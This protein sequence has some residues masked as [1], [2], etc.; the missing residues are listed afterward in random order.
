MYRE[1]RLK[2][3]MRDGHKALGCWTA[4][5]SALSTEIVAMAGFDFLLIDQE[6]GFGDPIQLAH[7]LQAMAAT[8]TT[9]VVRVPSHDPNYAKRVLDAGVESIM[10]PSVNTVEEACAIVKA[11]RYVPE[12]LRGMAQG[13]IRAS[14]YGYDAAEYVKTANQNLLLICQIETVE[15]VAN[16]EEL[17]AVEG[18]D[19]FFIGPNDLSASN[20]THGQYDDP[21]FIALM[22]KVE[23]T[24]LASDKMLATIPYGKY[25]WQDNFDKGY[26]MT[27]GGADVV[28]LR[29]ACTQIVEQHQ[30]RS[31]G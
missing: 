13:M 9:S 16:I 4:L 7:Q 12:G 20:N 30:A 14:N 11:C 26:H 28:L 24:V 29:N 23:S 19:M 2:K 25:S 8:Q 17:V 3:R 27:T 1:N 31:K 10:F 15:A 18:I 5:N 21:S 6:H 22:D